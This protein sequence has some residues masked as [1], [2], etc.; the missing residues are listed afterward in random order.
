V[1]A[2]VEI[3]CPCCQRLLTVRLELVAEA[4]VQGSPMAREANGE[5]QANGTV[6]LA[7]VERAQEICV[8]LGGNPLEGQELVLVRSALAQD[9]GGVRACAAEAKERGRNPVGLFLVKLRAGDH[10]RRSTASGQAPGERCWACGSSEGVQ[11]YGRFGGP[12]LCARHAEEISTG[13]TTFAELAAAE[14]APG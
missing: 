4:G 10:L 12:H 5:A 1:T 7:P 8:E 11:D 3:R 9:E 6:D 14:T 13:T 2:P